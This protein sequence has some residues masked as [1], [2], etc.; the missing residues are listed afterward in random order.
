M[1]VHTN[2]SRRANS[3]ADCDAQQS[4]CIRDG[5]DKQKLLVERADGSF[6]PICLTRKEIRVGFDGNPGFHEWEVRTAP[7][8]GWR[9]QCELAR[10][11]RLSPCW[12][13]N[14][15]TE[16]AVGHERF[17]ARKSIAHCCGRAGLD[18]DEHLDGRGLRTGAVHTVQLDPAQSLTQ[19]DFVMSSSAGLR[20]VQDRSQGGVC[21]SFTEDENELFEESDANLRGWKPD[22]S[23][24]KVA[25]ETLTYW[26][27]WNVMARLLFETAKLHRKNWNSRRCQ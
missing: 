11:D 26:R 27:N 18:G 8:L 12:V 7:D 17:T 21:C 20:L 16:N 10:T 15:K 5:A 14:P 4:S 3:W 22:D 13:V 25:A 9:L 2:C 23:W 6:Q 24:G 1:L 19:M